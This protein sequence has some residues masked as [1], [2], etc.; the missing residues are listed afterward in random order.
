M[1]CLATVGVFSDL[2]PGTRRNANQYLPPDS[3]QGYDYNKPSNGFPS[4]PA[5]PPAGPPARPPA[6]PARPPARPPSP[7]GGGYPPPGPK[8][9][10]GFPDYSG[11]PSGNTG[12]AVGGVGTRRIICFNSRLSV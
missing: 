12:N 3:K 10:P 5:R 11:A 9:Q 1:L 2:P 4:G 8:P 6:P 7:P